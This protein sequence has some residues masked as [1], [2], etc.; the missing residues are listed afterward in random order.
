[1]SNFLHSLSGLGVKAAAIGLMFLSASCQ[2]K[3]VPATVTLSAG[4]ATETSLSFTL[5]SSDADELCYSYS[6][7]GQA[8]LSGDQI[9]QKGTKAAANETKEYK[10]SGLEFNKSYDI[11][12]VAKNSLGYS[13]V[14]KVSM[15]TAT[16][17]ANVSVKAGEITPVSI[18][19]TVTSANVKKVAWMCVKAGESVPAADAILSGGKEVEAGK[20]VQ[21]IAE[22]LEPKTEYTLIAAASDI[23]GENAAASEPVKVTTADVPAP[24]V[25]VTAGENV[26]ESSIEF[27]VTSKNAQKVAW[28]CVKSGETVPAA[29]A[30]LSGGTEVKAGES[31]K[32]KAEGL[33]GGTE[34]IIVAA[35]SDMIGQNAVLSEQVKVSTLKPAVPQVG[36]YYYSDGTY[37]T[38]LDPAKTPI[39][40]V[41]HVGIH[42]KDAIAD[43]KLKDGKSPMTEIK[44][45]AVALKDPEGVDNNGV[46]WSYQGS[47]DNACGTSRERDDYKGYY[48]SA[49]VKQF[50]DEKK[51]GLSAE[52]SNFPAA[53]Y[54][55][56]K[57]EELVKAPESSSGWFLPSVQQ[58]KD[59]TN[60]DSTEDKYSVTLQP[61]IAA[62][63]KA[64]GD[65]AVAPNQKYWTS[66]EANISSVF[67]AY[68]VNLKESWNLGASTSERKDQN[69][70]GVRSIIVF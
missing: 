7:T 1:M 49:V 59:L 32:C 19:F 11:Y 45:Y 25:S 41:F 43:Y 21:C 34:Y 18:A 62:A 53:Y 44:A 37:S 47:W 51:G 26:T 36:D 46:L 64:L 42:K 35:A 29:E 67:Y 69:K 58:L 8:A 52:A 10:I 27:T 38:A 70:F 57:Q 22:N 30:V 54:A 17:S 66:T 23:N 20:E 68:Y 33:L 13:S 65:K 5:S 61:Q 60:Y 16:P 2:E 14:A 24:S 4:S 63:F 15:T 31:V 39:A 28:K 12:A 48:N 3:E 55:M 9:F 56:V 40:I 6:E 50:A